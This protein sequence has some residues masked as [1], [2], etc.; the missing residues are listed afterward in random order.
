MRGSRASKFFIFFWIACVFPPAGHSLEFDDLIAGGRTGA[1]GGASVALPD[2]YQAQFLNP[3]GL[4]NIEAPSVYWGYGHH[5]SLPIA[6][7][8]FN[9]MRPLGTGVAPAGGWQGTRSATKQLDRFYLSWSQEER[10]FP[11]IPRGQHR[12]AW[13]VNVR[14][15]SL[16]TRDAPEQSFKSKVGVGLDAGVL[17]AFTKSKTVLGASI[18]G[19]DSK[20]IDSDTPILSI[21]AL[22]RFGPLALMTDFRA[23]SGLNTFYP[24]VEFDLFHGLAQIRAGRGARLGLLRTVALGFGFNLLPLTVDLGLHVPYQGLHRREGSLMLSLG[25]A[26]GGRRY[27]ELFT[28]RAAESSQKLALDIETLEEKRH[29]TKKD[30]A[31]TELD[32]KIIKEEIMALEKRRREELA[33]DELKKAQAERAEE[34][35]K[36]KPKLIVEE[37]P[38]HHRVK[39]GDTL[40]QIATDYY[41]DPGFWELIYKSNPDKIIRGLPKVGATLVIPKPQ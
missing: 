19:L 30:L 26:F 11:G 14:T 10:G 13:G 38:K 8:H 27:Y 2:G 6:N 20:N 17:V 22:K 41:G 15:L 29:H 23:R 1:L 33:W 21:G 36:P 16:R 32:L 5:Y 37:W 40:R 3:A 31:E 18:I 4:V 9:Y 34:E 12:F 35:K 7:Y 24:A 39:E 28:G 25:W